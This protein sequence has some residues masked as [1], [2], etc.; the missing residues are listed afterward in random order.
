MRLGLAA[1]LGAAT[2]CWAQAPTG[3]VPKD[4]TGV[5]K[6]GTY[7]T[8]AKKSGAC[9]GHQGV[10]TWY[11]TVGGPMDPDIK[12]GGTSS[13][14]SAKQTANS[15]ST[16]NPHGDTTMS[17]ARADAINKKSPNAVVATPSDNGKVIPG[18]AA[19]GTANAASAGNTGKNSGSSA[20]SRREAAPGGGPNLVWL[21][22]ESNVYHCY[23][24][25]FYG[26][27][28]KGKYLP[29]QEAINGGGKPEGGKRCSPK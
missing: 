21:N 13:S 10:K 4:A 2:V 17:N 29:E 19:N 3:G 9:S 8:S 20:V 6:D 24:S 5:C 26:K 16:V 25:A 1:M 18:P 12:S 22:S 15:D 23:G 11:N 27:T 7:T 28:K 14:K